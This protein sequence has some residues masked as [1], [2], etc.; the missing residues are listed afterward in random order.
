MK[1][2]VKVTKLLQ[3]L[4]KSALDYYSNRLEIGTDLCS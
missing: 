2:K 3:N 1:V 4:I